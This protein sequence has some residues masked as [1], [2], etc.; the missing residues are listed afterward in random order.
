MINKSKQI[1]RGITAVCLLSSF[2]FSIEISSSAQAVDIAGK[3]RMFTQ[4]MLK[5]YAMVG[6]NNTFGKPDE[7]LK[8][9]ISDFDDAATS[10]LAYTKNDETKKSLEK[11]KS[12]WSPLKQLLG[13]TASIEKVGKLQEELEILLKASDDTTKLFA[14][15]LGNASGKIVN[16]A[17]RQRM[18]SQRMAGLYMLKVWGVEDPQFKEKMVKTMELFKTSL[19]ELEKSE[20]NTE[21]ITKLLAKVKRSFIFF[22][23]MNKSK[24]KFV[25]TL[26][27]K[28]SNDILKN[29][30]SATQAY[31][32]LETK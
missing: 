18:L 24:S 3:Q 9:I 26:I 5:D 22:E 17:G 8:K 23:M 30:N 21:E 12:L 25:P 6:M 2:S 1:G 4:R 29:M 7:D 32:A 28:K 27:Y 16:M 14:K 13:E 20:L 19:T 11:V 10:L 15:D 31:V